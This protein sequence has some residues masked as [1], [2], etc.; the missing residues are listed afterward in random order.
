MRASSA[1][2]R[3]VNVSIQNSRCGYSTAQPLISRLL[4]LLLRER[5]NFWVLQQTLRQMFRYWA[6]L[7]EHIVVI[8]DAKFTDRVAVERRVSLSAILIQQTLRNGS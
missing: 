1:G 8:A 3:S 7:L 4:I 6:R 5:T 2:S